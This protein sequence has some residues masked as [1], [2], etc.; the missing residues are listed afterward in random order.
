MGF[1]WRKSVRAGRGRRV[2][3]S[4]GGVSVSQRVGRRVTVSTRGRGSVR[5]LPGLSYRFRLWK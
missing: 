5:I 2:N 3:L 1:V 4:T